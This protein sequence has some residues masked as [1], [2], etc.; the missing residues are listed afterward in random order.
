MS[1]VRV[2]RPKMRAAARLMSDSVTGSTFSSADLDRNS[3]FMIVML[4]A[5]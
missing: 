2:T 4:R 3:L 5:K 1:G